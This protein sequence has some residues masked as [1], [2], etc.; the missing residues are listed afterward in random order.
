MV[1]QTVFTIATLALWPLR[2][3]S[4]TVLPVAGPKRFDVAITT[5]SLTDSDRLDPF[6]GDGRARSIMVSSFNPVASCLQTHLEAYMPPATAAFL[7]DKFSAYGL[8]NG[9]FRSL[10]IE[11]CN[12]TQRGP[13]SS[14][15][16]PLVLFS[17]A[18][19]TSRLIY[20]SM[21][22]SIA[23]TGYLVVS[24]DH[25][26]DADV[27]EFLDGTTVTGKDISSDEDIE[28]ALATRVGDITFVRQQM[29]NATIADN[30]FP[31]H[32]LGNRLPKTA[33]IGHS[34]G[35]ATAAS[36]MLQ[37]VSIN[38]GLN[39]D[40]SM[41]GKVLEAGLDRPFML[42]GHENKTQETD[43]SWKAIWLQIKEWK[44]EFEVKG[45][46]HY[47][48]SDLPLITAV[49]G[50]QEQLPAEVAEFL[51][52][53]EGHHMT[54]LIVEYVSMFLDLVLKNGS[55]NGL[56]ESNDNFPEVVVGA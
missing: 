45:A 41:F 40:G 1:Y 10:Q 23:A 51:G 55:E 49:L 11:T 19:E 4:A 8:P 21:L 48:F 35:G 30:L 2:A 25:P 22:Q 17:G 33:V 53:I 20:T 3:A 43:P 24:I 39:L 13:C 29:T 12:T 44:A 46:A 31:G 28:L 26:Y 9:S 27:V 36:A 42:M 18:S 52:T 7:D 56:I 6:T 15:N 50:L 54:E 32:Q 14:D 38:A 16:F 47:S 34:L 5:A 37:D